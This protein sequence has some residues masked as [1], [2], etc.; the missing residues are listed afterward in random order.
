MDNLIL[1]KIDGVIQEIRRKYESSGITAADIFIILS[2]EMLRCEIVL[3]KVSSNSVSAIREIASTTS[4]FYYFRDYPFLYNVVQDVY[5]EISKID[6]R[7]NDADFES[8][9]NFGLDS[10]TRHVSDTSSS[11][12]KELPMSYFTK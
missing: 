1:K 2:F 12:L 3:K 11:L 5:I 7:F 6:G 4:H 8:S 10:W 9:V